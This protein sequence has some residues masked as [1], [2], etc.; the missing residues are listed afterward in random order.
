M[1]HT[2]RFR[3]RSAIFRLERLEDRTVLSPFLV[4]NLAD[5]GADSLRQAILDANANPGADVITFAPKSARD[6]HP[7]QR[8]VADRRTWG[9]WTSKGLAPTS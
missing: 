6:H 8:R 4:S 3:R 1:L 9:A 2:P 5:S 7:D